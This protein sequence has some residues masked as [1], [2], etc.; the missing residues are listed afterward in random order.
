MGHAA[1]CDGIKALAWDRYRDLP[2]FTAYTA[3]QPNE[4][5]DD[6]R[7]PERLCRMLTYADVW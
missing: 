6:G 5:A 4:E 1:L 2:A 7:S 3:P